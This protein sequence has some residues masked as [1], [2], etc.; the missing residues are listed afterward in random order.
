MT[1][2]FVENVKK[3]V[4]KGIKV[5][6]DA[7]SKAGTTAS[8]WGD[9]GVKKVELLQLS[10]KLKEQ[11]EKLG[12]AVYQ[13]IKDGGVL[14]LTEK[15]ELASPYFEKIDELKTAIVERETSEEKK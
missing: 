14:S 4:D 6:K 1:M 5:S 10:A 3:Y 2:A 15:S 7:F 12:E 9:Q 11:Y 8:R 13:A